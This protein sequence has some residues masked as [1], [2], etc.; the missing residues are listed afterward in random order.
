VASSLADPTSSWSTTEP[1]SGT[2]DVAYDTWF[3]QSPVASGQPNGAEVMVWL[4]HQ[5][6]VQ[7]AGSP[8]ATV[9]LDGHTFQVWRADMPSW[10][11]VAYVIQGGA[12]SVTN[13]DLGNVFRDAEARGYVSPSWYLIDVEAGFE[14]WQGGAGL[15]T[16]AFAFDPAGT[17]SST[18]TSSTTTTTG[19]TT[20]TT[21]TADD[22]V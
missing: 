22:R 17:T 1:G 21:S 6:P 3:N 20:T 14:L 8:V 4:N 5:G 2:Y 9:G 13:L 10:T 19:P 7:P 11:Y 12:T 18:T 16:T 15:G